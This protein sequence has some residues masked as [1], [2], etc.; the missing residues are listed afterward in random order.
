[1]A[2][3][4]NVESGLCS[5]KPHLRSWDRISIF[6]AK[7]NS[8][9]M[10][11]QLEALEH[12]VHILEMLVMASGHYSTWLWP[13]FFFSWCLKPILWLM[14]QLTSRDNSSGNWFSKNFWFFAPKSVLFATLQKVPESLL[15]FYKSTIPL[16][17]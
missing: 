17:F 8:R 7:R 12:V 14:E 3:V 13:I 4:L 6:F 2:T 11:F 10:S 1:M 9:R 5:A 15:M 16:V